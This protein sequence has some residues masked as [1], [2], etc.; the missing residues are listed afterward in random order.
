MTTDD[1]LPRDKPPI[2]SERSRRVTE[3]TIISE[4]SV[5]QFPDFRRSRRAI[6]PGSSSMGTTSGGASNWWTRRGGPLSKAKRMCVEESCSAGL[7][8]HLLAHVPE[9]LLRED[10]GEVVRGAVKGQ[11]LA[12]LHHGDEALAHLVVRSVAPLHEL[13]RAIGVPRMRGVVEMG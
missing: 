1:M 4:I 8:G 13:G 12:F 3:N 7:L 2:E 5:L 11:V 9:S 6:I 10:F